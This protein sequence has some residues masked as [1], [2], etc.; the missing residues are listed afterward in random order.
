MLTKFRGLSTK[1]FEFVF[2]FYYKSKD[3]KHFIIDE[4]TNKIQRVM[5]YSVGQFTGF[6]D[7]NGTEI[8]TKDI[9]TEPVECDGVIV[10]SVEPVFFEKARN[11]FAVD[12]SFNKDETEFEYLHNIDLSTMEVQ[13]E[14]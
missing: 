9:L 5:G 3:K 10:N 1:D 11:I 13:K 6:K 2:G 7:K 14:S 12:C 4:V 8:Y